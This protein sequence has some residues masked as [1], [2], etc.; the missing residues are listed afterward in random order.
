MSPWASTSRE[1]AG[2]CHREATQSSLKGHG[3]QVEFL[4]VGRWQMPPWSPKGQE[5]RARELPAG[6]PYLHWLHVLTDLSGMAC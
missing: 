3:H 2:G 5:G 6:Q 1:R 4:R